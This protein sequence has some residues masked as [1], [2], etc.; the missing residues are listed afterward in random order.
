MVVGGGR[1][2]WTLVVGSSSIHAAHRP[3]RPAPLQIFLLDGLVTETHRLRSLRSLLAVR[4]AAQHEYSRCWVTQDKLHFQAKQ[5]KDKGRADK[6]DQLELKI[7]E[8]VGLMKRA[9]ERCVGGLGGRLRTRVASL[10][11]SG[12]LP[13]PTSAEVC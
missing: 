7:Q 13:F 1:E 5:W 8:A 4:E 6:A 10:H 3:P 2:L 9:K 12:V 11:T